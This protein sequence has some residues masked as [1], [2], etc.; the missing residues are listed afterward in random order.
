MMWMH[1]QIMLRVL[2]RVPFAYI[3][4]FFHSDIVHQ[5]SGA[6]H[7]EER[8]FYTIDQ[9]KYEPGANVGHGLRGVSGVDPRPC[10]GPRDAG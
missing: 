1:L 4:Y 7:K 5:S 2:L 10:F 9:D 8:N 3:L 6:V